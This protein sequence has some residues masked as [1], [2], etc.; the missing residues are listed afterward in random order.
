MALLLLLR[1][2]KIRYTDCE[3]GLAWRQLDNGLLV[4]A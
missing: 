4:A 1:D 2:T 3:F